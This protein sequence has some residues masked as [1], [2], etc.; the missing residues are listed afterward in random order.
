MAER[1][2][3]DSACAALLVHIEGALVGPSSAH[4]A[5]IG[6]VAARVNLCCRS[7]FELGIACYPL[8]TQLSGCDRGAH[9]AARLRP[10]AAVGEATRTGHKLDVGKDMLVERAREIETAESGRVDEH[11]PSRHGEQLSGCCGVATPVIAVTH[12]ADR[13]YVASD[14]RV[15]KGGLPRSRRSEHHGSP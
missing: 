5:V 6:P 9:G 15:D 8:G 1:R 2:G 3:T 7:T 4:A 10:M 13:E 11:A 12:R 14:K